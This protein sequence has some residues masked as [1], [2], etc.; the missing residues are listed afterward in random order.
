MLTGDVANATTITVF[1]PK[2][3]S[4]LRW[5][6]KELT[7]TSSKEGILTAEVGGKVEFSLPALGPWKAADS[8]PE[9]QSNYSATSQAWV[10]ANKAETPNPTVPDL[11][12]PI[13]YVDDYD[14]H[15]GT[16]IYRATF[17]SSDQPPIGVFLNVTGG[18]AFGYSVWLNSQFIGSWLGLSYV[19]KAGLTFSFENATLRSSDDNVLV[20]VMDNS[21]HDQRAEALNPRGITNATLV[22]P[23]TYGFNEWKIAGTAGRED[24][25]DRVRGSLNEGGLYAERVGMHLPGFDDSSWPTSEGPG[26]S[27][28]G[29]GVRI[30]RTVVPLSV[31]RGL[32]VSISF[33]MTAPSNDTFESSSGGTNQLRALLFVNG[34]QYGRFN[35]YIGNQIDFPVP[36]G[37]L[38]Y[39]GDNTIAVTVWSQTADG[40]EM[41]VEW[42]VDY[43]H[44]TSYDM[45]F[46]AAYLRP[47]WGSERLAYD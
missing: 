21:G 34:Y 9:I 47:G 7:I 27:V 46:D 15:V 36:P 23:G 41:K 38:D 14:I 26:L 44:E 17:G 32:D 43:V 20:V 45:N 4:C 33:R 6:D 35:P 22:G 8:L 25:L 12:N 16:H 19:D 28:P 18:T 37:I 2:S 40:V 11:T 31:P 42:N 13:L 30:F 10:V 24:V 1:A 29:P 5:N 39:D 3:I